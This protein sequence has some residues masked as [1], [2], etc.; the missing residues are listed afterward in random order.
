MLEAMDVL[1]EM[2]YPGNIIDPGDRSKDSP[3]HV[4]AFNPKCDSDLVKKIIDM[5]ADVNAENSVGQT[6]LF[7]MIQYTRCPE[8]VKL[9]LDN[10]AFV[11]KLDDFHASPLHYA[12]SDCQFNLDVV[13]LLLE[14]GAHIDETTKEGEEALH[15]AARLGDLDVVTLLLDSGAAVNALD[16]RD[17]SPLHCAL[18]GFVLDQ[19]VIKLLL[20]RGAHILQQNE[21]GE[22]PLHLAAYKGNFGIV[23]LLLDNGALVNALDNDYQSPLNYAL[24]AM[25]C[26]A[27]VIK[28]LLERGEDIHKVNYNGE[29]ILH[30]AAYNCKADIIQLLIDH[31]AYVNAL[32]LSAKSPLMCALSVNDSNPEAVKVLVK[33]KSNLSQEDAI[34]QQPLHLATNRSDFDT[35]KIL[36]DAGA[37]PNA[38][39]IMNCS[40]LLNACFSS[41]GDS[42]RAIVKLLLEAG[43]KV[44]LGQSPMRMSYCE[45]NRRDLRA[46]PKKFRT[47]FQTVKLLIKY[48]VLEKPIRY[49]RGFCRDR[50]TDQC[51]FDY[52]KACLV[53][54]SSKCPGRNFRLR[55][56]LLRQRQIA[57]RDVDEILRVL[58][59]RPYPLYKQVIASLLTKRQL[60][61]KLDEQFQTIG[62]AHL[63][64]K[65]P[66][67]HVAL[68]IVARYISA[69]KDLLNLSLAFYN[70]SHPSE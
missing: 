53:E 14:D 48:S 32:D 29:Q 38:L 26:N 21:E 12:L 13:R 35:V 42:K 2:A 51:L 17:Q 66:L 30:L 4:A 27:E 59:K 20:D 68:F 24:N 19:R 18:N 49:C 63:K 34:G 25:E 31:G 61:Q 15:L 9:F 41:H 60:R 55:E 43:A 52:T 37:S 36:L 65:V 40:P 10:G 11:N 8:I 5:G 57:D 54:L 69:H 45:L 28:L 58:S 3:L 23:K 39:N 1:W 7:Y 33:N 50:T 16:G 56:F 67:I 22:Q 44:F 64:H 70:I 46:N 62:M 6:P 47:A